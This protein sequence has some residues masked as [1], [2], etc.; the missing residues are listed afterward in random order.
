MSFP[1]LNAASRLRGAVA[2]GGT[3]AAR[4]L[5]YDPIPLLRP[6]Y[7]LTTPQKLQALSRRPMLYSAMSN[8]SALDQSSTFSTEPVATSDISDGIFGRQGESE[9]T[10]GT[11]STEGATT[12]T[13]A[14]TKVAS[15]SSRT[16][17]TKSRKPQYTPEIDAEI[18]RLRGLGYSWTAVGSA[19][20]MG[21]RSCHHRFRTVLDPQLKEQ[22]WPNEKIQRLETMVAEGKPWTEIARELES[23]TANCMTKWNALVRPNGETRSRSFDVVQ[24]RVLLKL[25]EQYGEDDWRSVL[26]GFMEQLGSRNM[27]KVTPDQLKHQ[28]YRLRRRPTHVW[29]VQEETALI[30]HVLKQGT[31]HWEEIS[32]ALQSHSPEQC[33]E[34]WIMLDMKSRTPEKEKMWYK[35]EKSNFWR[36][37]LRY[38]NDWATVAEYLPKRTPEQCQ[39]FYERTTAA[40]KPKKGKTNSDDSENMKEQQ[41]EQVQEQVQEQKEEEDS[42]EFQAK[43]KEFA[44]RQ[45]EML[46]ITW[47]KEDSEL[48]KKVAE[49]VRLEKGDKRVIWKEVAKRMHLGLTSAQYKHHH[50]YLQSTENGGLAGP[51]TDEEIKTLEHAV[52]VVGR[53]WVKI[54][55]EYMPHRNPKSLC[56]KFRMMANKGLHISFEEYD[57][58]MSQVDLQEE[59][60]R[61]KNPTAKFIPNWEAISKV[62]PTGRVWEA[63]QCKLA[64]ES[65]F[66]NHIQHSK[67]TTEEDEGLVKAVQRFGRKNWVGVAQLV[68]GKSNW[69]CQ[70]RWSQLHDPV[71]EDKESLVLLNKALK[72]NALTAQIQQAQ[73]Q[74]HQQ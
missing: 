51:W 72:R 65:S 69:E 34:R 19:L 50:Y 59:A 18:I 54:S 27:A 74:Q 26:R 7:R 46:V 6:G 32:Q 47:K 24:S 42:E 25:V 71:L 4:T 43:I 3:T 61:Q 13:T 62:M 70:M 41:Q 40:L 23:T 20:G 12:T 15:I 33:R 10:T 17:N 63:D 1:L 73:Q 16:Y 37:W 58:L 22:A 9:E 64:Y 14:T 8:Y 52:L 29:T 56:H 36:L 44:Q 67:W 66:K 68:P 49:E 53:N 28:Y 38:G 11:T 5:K 35:G 60:F 39:R 2:S 45:V 48:L 31:G 21:H 30:Q 57:T 55:A